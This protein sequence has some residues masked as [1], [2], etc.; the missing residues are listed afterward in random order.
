MEEINEELSL[1][2]QGWKLHDPGIGNPWENPAERI[3]IRSQ[4]I[5]NMEPRGFSD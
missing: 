1:V 2:W 5:S 3:C 4:A